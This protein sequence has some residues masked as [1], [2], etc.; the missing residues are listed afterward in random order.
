MQCFVDDLAKT[1]NLGSKFIK[2]QFET[3]VDR[4]DDASMNTMENGNESLLREEDAIEQIMHSELLGSNR[5]EVTTVSSTSRFLYKPCPSTEIN[6]SPSISQLS[7]Q[8]VPTYTTVAVIGDEND[9]DAI[10]DTLSDVNAQSSDQRPTVSN[11]SPVAEKQ[12]CSSELKEELGFLKRQNAQ[13]I[14]KLNKE[15]NKQ[16]KYGESDVK[17][18][19][20]SHSV[21]DFELWDSQVTDDEELYKA[22]KRYLQK[23]KGEATNSNHYGSVLIRIVDDE[24]LSHYN[25]GGVHNK[26]QLQKHAVVEMLYGKFN[27][28]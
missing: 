18:M 6:R 15:F 21:D 22:T 20:P 1:S 11:S 23:F 5:I 3:T 12:M 14:S 8:P 17:K 16:R 26:F 13:I 25:Y 10:T 28:F 2:T 24:V 7:Q 4:A 27:H 9:T 19:I